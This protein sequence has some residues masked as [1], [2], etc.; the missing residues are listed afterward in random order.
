MN[1]K[2]IKAVMHKEFLHIIRD[3]RSLGIALLAPAVLLV[4]YAYAVTFD[5][6]KI[7]IAVIDSDFTVSSRAYI[8]NMT[9]SGY[10]EIN[11][12]ASVSEKAAEQA[13]M[14][15]KV[16]FILSVPAGFE[17][18]IKRSKEAVVQVTAD[19]ADANTASV[20][21]GY[22]SLITMGYS[23]EIMLEAV[24]ARG[25]NPKRMPVVEAVPRVWYNPELKSTNF[26]VPG[27]ISII[28]M[29][30]AATLTSLTVVRERER[31][32][33]EQLISTPVKAGE[34]IIGKL[35]PYIIIGLVDVAIIFLV[36]TLWFK[37]PFRGDF[38]TFAAFTLLFLFGSMGL[39][40]LISST[41]KTQS[42][43]VLGT[44]FATML[45]SVLLS[46]FIFPV[47]S[48]PFLIQLI[49]YLVPARYYLTA[50]RSLF[51]KAD[52]SIVSLAPEGVFLAV[53]G[54][55]FLAIAAKRFKKKID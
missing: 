34:L 53:F 21:L 24:R 16:K 12:S 7:D 15:N 51:L 22:L 49:T 44:V 19:G 9:S 4:I 6:K 20:G 11:T 35:T 18:A 42:A 47:Q 10:F 37:V 55:I 46:G 27:L 36:G 1:L 33:F 29:L 14:E 40:L 39:G 30:I 43:A 52:V 41:A 8:N 28:M 26:I 48:M 23:R 32:S 17:K 50:L 38:L 3:P 13:L 5:I 2:R 45:P 31:G 54:F 25:F